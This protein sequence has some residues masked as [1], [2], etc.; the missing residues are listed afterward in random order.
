MYAIPSHLISLHCHDLYQDIHVLG[1]WHCWS[2]F[3]AC[4]CGV[5]H[6]CMSNVMVLL[7]DT[8][9]IL[10]VYVHIRNY[11]WLGIAFSIFAYD[12]L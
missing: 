4:S 12:T 10:R 9:H 7:C 3:Y 2:L 1:F 6:M 8:S 11:I 5:I